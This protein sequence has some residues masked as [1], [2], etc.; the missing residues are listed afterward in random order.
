LG[1]NVVLPRFGGEKEA[2]PR[3]SWKEEV[4]GKVT[5]DLKLWIAVDGGN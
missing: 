4:E 1:K 5:L 3:K 2:D